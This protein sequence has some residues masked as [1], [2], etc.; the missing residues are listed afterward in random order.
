MVTT[1]KIVERISD[2]TYKVYLPIFQNAGVKSNL[3]TSIYTANCCVDPFVYRPYNVD[4]LVFVG[5]VNNRISQP[6]I[7]GKILKDGIDKPSSYLY[8]DSLKVEKSVILPT[9]TSIVSSD[10]QESH[11]FSLKFLEQQLNE[12][13]ALSD[14]IDFINQ[15]G[16]E[17]YEELEERIEE[18]YNTL[19]KGITS[20]TT[21]DSGK[22][23]KIDSDG[24]F[25][26]T[27]DKGLLELSS[28]D[29]GKLVV[30][31]SNGDLTT[32]PNKNLTSISST[33]SGKIISVDNNGNL[34]PVGNK[35][36]FALS[37][38]DEG[39]LLTVDSNGNIISSSTQLVELFNHYIFVQGTDDTT[40]ICFTLT[41]QFNYEFQAQNLVDY[42]NL[43][44]TNQ[45]TGAGISCT[46]SVRISAMDHKQCV[47]IRRGNVNQ[48]DPS[49][50]IQ[51][52][53]IK[54]TGGFDSAVSLTVSNITS[55]VDN[56]VRIF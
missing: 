37:S 24:N 44:L 31:D 36:I 3:N 51:V 20:I 48:G 34:S 9:D 35:G 17:D 13:Q 6:I 33:D 2:S 8:A 5:F 46:G 21:E 43:I 55:V 11:L 27:H 54:A 16:S 10:G 1:G 28:N 42:V 26:P 29:S 38:A 12:L 41:T 52:M 7:L 32:T 4:D 53:P 40:V 19:N 30:V 23:V 15:E 25:S 39:K 47:Q 45:G 22:L 14:K 56:V 50:S 49:A 18:V